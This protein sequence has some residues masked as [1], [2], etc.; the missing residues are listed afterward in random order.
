MGGSFTLVVVLFGI[1][2]GVTALMLYRRR[3]AAPKTANPT[4]D[5]PVEQKRKAAQWGVRIYASDKEK[6]CPQ[7]RPILGKEFALA[8]RPPLPVQGCVFSTH[9]ECQYVKLFD[10]RKAERRSGKERR[11]LQR[12]EQGKR[13]RR[14]GKDRRKNRDVDWV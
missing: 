14:M 4:A 1:V 6:A 9:C 8:E 13:D 10:R 2:A 11:Q 5:E 12:F 7:V 3:S